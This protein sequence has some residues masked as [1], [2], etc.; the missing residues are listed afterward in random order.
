MGSN[1]KIDFFSELMRN[2]PS[3]L[4]WQLNASLCLSEQEQ[5]RVQAAYELFSFNCGEPLQKHLAEAP[6]QPLALYDRLELSWIVVPEMLEGALQSVH[7]LGPTFTSG[8]SLDSLRVI[9]RSCR[10]PSALTTTF[11]RFFQEIPITAYVS[12][13]QYGQMLYHTVTGQ[14]ISISDFRTHTAKPPQRKQPAAQMPHSSAWVFEQLA[15]EM[16]E[17]GQLH[18]QEAFS[19]LSALQE[20]VAPFESSSY[21]RMNKNAIISF[22]TLATRAAIR[23]GLDP[24]TAY[25]VGNSYIESV[26]KTSALPELARLNQMMYEDFIHRVRKV[27]ESSGISPEIMAACNYIERHITEKITVDTLAE[28]AG[29]SKVYFSQKFRKEMG[30]SIG[31]YLKQQKVQRAK[32]LLQSTNLSIQEIGLQLGF[33]NNSYFAETFKSVTGMSPGAYR[34]N[35]TGGH[36]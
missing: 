16:I 19:R 26:E 21:T 30:I 22:I 23:G 27:R 20:T 24:E 4:S 35:G 14:R 2:G 10:Y 28:N 32:L 13:M 15:M 9:M 29:Y 18:Y 1:E 36:P 31:V 8:V 34:E 6:E 7:I 3:L 12:W 33:C 11:E 5:P 25:Y 17:R